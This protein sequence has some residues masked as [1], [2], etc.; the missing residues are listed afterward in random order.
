[1]ILTD[2][3]VGPNAKAL[4]SSQKNG[5]MEDESMYYTPTMWGM[6]KQVVAGVKKL[7]KQSSITYS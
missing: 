6:L 1:M 5:R 4:T 2:A 7:R 3:W